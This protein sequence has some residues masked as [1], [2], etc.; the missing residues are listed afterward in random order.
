MGLTSVAPASPSPPG[1]VAACS[2]PG[3]APPA[4]AATAAPSVATPAAAAATT[5][6]GVPNMCAPLGALPAMPASASPPAALGGRGRFSLMG[7]MR[8]RPRGRFTPVGSSPA[9]YCCMGR[10][11]AAAGAGA[12][13][14]LLLVS[15][16]CSPAPAAAAAAAAAPPMGPMPGRSRGCRRRW[17]G[18][19]ASRY[20]S[21]SLRL[22]HCSGR[23]VVNGSTCRHGGGAVWG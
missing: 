23:T 4:A 5:C 11:G 19:K 1:V 22:V 14:R 16:A 9:P 17:G 6:P 10:T 12:A 21:T 3:V 8:G 2:L 7:W 18:M 15:P 20:F 13:P